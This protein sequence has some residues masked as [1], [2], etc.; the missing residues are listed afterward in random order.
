[1]RQ[2]LLH[3]FPR[4]Y[5]RAINGTFKKVGCID[6]LVLTGQVNDFEYFLFQVAHRMIEIIEDFLR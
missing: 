4:H 1:M 2:R 6:N 3:D 5:R